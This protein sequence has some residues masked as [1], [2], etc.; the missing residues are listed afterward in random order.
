MER[1]P[2]AGHALKPL[3]VVLVPEHVR[4]AARFERGSDAVGPD[5][6]LGVGEAGNEHDRVKLPLE[7]MVAGQAAQHKPVRVGQDDADRLPVELLVQV[8]QHRLGGAGQVRAE[9][10]RAQVAHVQV[11]GR[12]VPLP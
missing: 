9:V 1:H 12:D 3:R 7:V 11:V 4:G 6:F 10:R 8:P 2:G 5:D